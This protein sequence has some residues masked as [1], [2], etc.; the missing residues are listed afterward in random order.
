[1]RNTRRNDSITSSPVTLTLPPSLQLIMCNTIKM[2]TIPFKMTCMIR[3]RTISIMSYRRLLSRYTRILN[4]TKIQQLR[5]PNSLRTNTLTT[6]L[7]KRQLPS[8]PLSVNNV[9]RKG[10]SRPNVRLR[11]PAIALLS[12]RNR[13][14]M[15]K[16]RTILPTRCKNRKLCLKKMSSVTT[17]TNLRRCNISISNLRTIR[18]NNRINALN[19]VIT[20][21]LLTQPIRSLSNNRPCNTMLTLKNVGRL[22]LCQCQKE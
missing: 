14:I 4:N 11:A 6:L 20:P 10:N 1:M 21:V 12:N 3:I 8:I 17:C 16:Y 15:I 9:T 2:T 19:N 7:H 22:Y 13:K 5:M 18:S